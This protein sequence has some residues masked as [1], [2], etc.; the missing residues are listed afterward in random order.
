[1]QPRDFADDLASSAER[2]AKKKKKQKTDCLK[3]TESTPCNS[4]HLGAILVE[5]TQPRGSPLPVRSPISIIYL[6][7]LSVCRD[8][9]FVVKYYR[10]YSNFVQLKKR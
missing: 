2:F 9:L 3:S 5:D 4:P 7:L 1:M 6:P 8:E 10:V